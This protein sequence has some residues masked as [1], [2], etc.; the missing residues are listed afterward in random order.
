MK[1]IIEIPNN[2]YTEIKRGNLA[3]GTF[4]ELL[5]AIWNSTEVTEEKYTQI[6]LDSC[7]HK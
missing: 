1:L 5:K 6:F 4:K 2:I 3:E 7:T